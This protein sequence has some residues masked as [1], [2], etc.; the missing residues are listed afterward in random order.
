MSEFTTKTCDLILW[1]VTHDGIASVRL[2]MRGHPSDAVL[3][4]TIGG[5]NASKQKHTWFS[6]NWRRL[7]FFTTRN[8]YRLRARYLVH[9]IDSS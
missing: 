9:R 8:P 7:G 1:A 4:H 6:T 2:L 5:I 3:R